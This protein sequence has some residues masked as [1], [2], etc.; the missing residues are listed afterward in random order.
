MLITLILLGAIG[1]FL[2]FIGA[3]LESGFRNQFP[4]DF[5]FQIGWV[6]DYFEKKGFQH[7]T[8][9]NGGTEYPESVLVRNDTEEIIVRLN[10]PLSDSV[11]YTITIIAS[12]QSK[13]WNFKEDANKE[14]VY[15]KLDC[16]F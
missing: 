5:V 1:G 16:Y 14:D 4:D 8:N 9:R 11:P 13:E 10:A 15:K 2:W 7:V 6:L 12:N 3:A